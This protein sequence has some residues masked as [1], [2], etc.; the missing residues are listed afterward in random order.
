MSQS[1]WVPARRHAIARRRRAST[2]LRRGLAGTTVE[3]ACDAVRIWPT[4]PTH[5]SP[6]RNWMAGHQIV[7]MLPAGQ[8]LDA[9][10]PG[11]DVLVLG[12]DVEAELIG[13]IIQIGN[14]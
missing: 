10:K 6:P 11:R 3:R 13:R 12:R 2:R 9:L 14:E 8:R 5:A 7:R 4:Q 1:R